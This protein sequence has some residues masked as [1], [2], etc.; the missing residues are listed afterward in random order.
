M[1]FK[2]TVP[3]LGESVVEGTISQWLKNEGDEIKIDEPLVEIMTDKINIE[4]PS[5]HNGVLKKQLVAIAVELLKPRNDN[6][7]SSIFRCHQEH[8]SSSASSTFRLE[9]ALSVRHARR[10]FQH[11]LTFAN[12]WLAVDHRDRPQ[13][14]VW[15]PKPPNLFGLNVRGA[16]RFGEFHDARPRAFSI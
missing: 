9:K 4:I 15:L 6:F 1:D 3:P 8:P 14:Y 11:E 5:P 16:Y 13:R 10:N 12:S 7:R 2:L